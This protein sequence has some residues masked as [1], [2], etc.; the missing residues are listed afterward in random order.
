MN[1]PSNT[2]EDLK[3]SGLSNAQKY[4]ALVIGEDGF[5]PLFKYE[6]TA[7]V[8]SWV[9]GALGLL[10]RSKLYPRLLAECGRGSVFGANV[11]LRHPKKIRLGSG[12]IVDDSVVIDAKGTTNK[13]ISIGN[14]V[15]VGR[16][17]IVYCQNGNIT[18][19]SGSN[20][21]SNSQIFSSGNCVIGDNVLIAAYVYLVGGG[22][23]FSEDDIPVIEQDRISKGIRVGDGVWI[24]AGVKILD[25][26]TIGR[27]AVLAA[28]S[29]VTK[30]VPERAI[31]GGIP[32]QVLRMRDTPGGES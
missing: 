18:I 28:G 9:P 31:V 32:A 17:T 24:G 27:D 2:Q 7:L 26:V 3:A 6:F 8:A 23:D 4:R 22:H 11:L 1:K 10:L 16:N 14:D 29:V 19:G 5:W 13:G 15:F 25:G 12:V 30:D 20:I 21:G